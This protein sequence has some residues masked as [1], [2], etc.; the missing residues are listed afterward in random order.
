MFILTHSAI[1]S[2]KNCRKKYFW[3]YAEQLVPKKTPRALTLGRLVHKGI[4]MLTRTDDFESVL[5]G[6]LD[7]FPL[8]IADT[9][10]ELD[11]FESDKVVLELLLK[12][13]LKRYSLDFEA[14]ISFENKIRDSENKLIR[15]IKIAG[16]IDG[17]DSDWII[18]NKTFTVL[19]NSLIDQLYLDQQ[20]S[21][22]FYE[23]MKSRSKVFKGIKYRLLRKPSIK[24]NGSSLD[25]FIDRLR[26]DYQEREDFYFPAEQTLIRSTEDFSSYH[27]SLSSVVQDIRR[28]H[29]EN[30]WYKNTDICTKYSGCPYLRLCKEPTQET[31][32]LF[33]KYEPRNIELQKEDRNAKSKTRSTIT[34]STN[35]ANP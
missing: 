16:R 23:S 31:I 13:Y 5:N 19:E 24:Q 28:C 30:R 15:G 20:I 2:F 11:K 9:Q 33:F 21:I 7:E 27:H 25:K 10:E 34:E 14:E 18:E 32:K 6:L 35:R 8:E 12:G 4:A 17:I 1:Q 22:Y 3:R 26:K 29:K